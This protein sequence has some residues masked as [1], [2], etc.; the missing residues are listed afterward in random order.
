MTDIALESG[1]AKVPMSFWIIS[2]LSL[3]WNCFGGFDYT[4]TRMRNADYIASAGMNPQDVFA[5]VD[6]FPLIA[7][8]AWGLGVWGS[9]AGSLLLLMRS[10]HAVTAFIVSLLGAVVSFTYQYTLPAPASLDTTMNKVMP[11]VIIGVVVF[12]WW[13]AR[14]ARTQGILR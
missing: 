10:R 12:L 5:W 6:S 8:I 7:Q 13:F 14:R 9:V 1:A 2:G 3:L 4:M 11:L